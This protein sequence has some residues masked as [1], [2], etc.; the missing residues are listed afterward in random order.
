MKK[1]HIFPEWK[2]KDTFP[3]N[4]NENET[5]T[6]PQLDKILD[7][8]EPQSRLHSGEKQVVNGFLLFHIFFF[9]FFTISPEKEVHDEHL[10]IVTHQVGR[11]L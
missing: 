5:D 1:K 11:S 7:A 10:F 4:E 3:W 8:Q 2:W 6:F 9:I